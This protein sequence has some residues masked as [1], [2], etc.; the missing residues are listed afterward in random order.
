MAQLKSIRTKSTV[1]LGRT[2]TITVAKWRAAEES[3]RGEQ[4]RRAQKH[5][6]N[7]GFFEHVFRNTVKT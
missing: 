7:L 2:G 1:I 5:H 6:K 4:Q 3:N